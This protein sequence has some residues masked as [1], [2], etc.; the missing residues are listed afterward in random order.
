MMTEYSKDNTCKSENTILTVHGMQ[1]FS[2]LIRAWLVNIEKLF[3]RFKV[4]AG[5]LNTDS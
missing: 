3:R 5:F 1:G 4:K 2:G